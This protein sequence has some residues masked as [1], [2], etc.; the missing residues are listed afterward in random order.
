MSDSVVLATALSWNCRL[1]LCSV[2]QVGIV[3]LLLLLYDSAD[4]MNVMDDVMCDCA[5]CDQVRFGIER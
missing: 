1:P 3:A 2:Y 5:T 4:S